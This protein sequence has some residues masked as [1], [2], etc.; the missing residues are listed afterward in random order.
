MGTAQE[1]RIDPDGKKHPGGLPDS[2]RTARA[3][4]RAV[5]AEAVAARDLSQ[6]RAAELCRTDQPTMSKVISGRTDSVTI[7][8]LVRWLS[9]LGCTIEVHLHKPKVDQEGALKV[10]VHE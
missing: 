6:T 7:D 9:A 3:R 2:S 10:V 8:Q 4:L 1:K 5:L